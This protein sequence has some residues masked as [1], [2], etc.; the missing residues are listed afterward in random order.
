MSEDDPFLPTHPNALADRKRV[1][2]TKKAKKMRKP[3]K[4]KSPM[5]RSKIKITS[6]T[7]SS[8]MIKTRKYL[9]GSKLENRKNSMT[10]SKKSHTTND[11]ESYSYKSKSKFWKALNQKKS[12][13]G[14]IKKIHKDK[15]L[16]GL[17]KDLNGSKI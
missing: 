15:F 14:K 16:S 4:K 13:M 10:G 3:N 1:V 8:R 6:G 7:K 12:K 2:V 17:L 11:T 5:K 9:K